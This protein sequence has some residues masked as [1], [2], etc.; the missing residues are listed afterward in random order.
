MTEKDTDEEIPEV[1]RVKHILGWYTKGELEAAYKAI[2][3]PGLAAKLRCSSETVRNALRKYS[4]STKVTITDNDLRT[5]S[6]NDLIAKYDCSLPTVSQ[7]RREAGIMS[8][9]I[10]ITD[11][12]LRTMSN[13]DLTVKYNCSIWTARRIRKKTGIKSPRK[14]N[15]KNISKQERQC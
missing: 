9:K 1:V 14:T 3:M 7:R 6:N 11:S 12:D 8:P 10:A 5:M 13:D 15:E 4:I 2:G